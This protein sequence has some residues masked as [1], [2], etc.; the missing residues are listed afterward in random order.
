MRARRAIRVG[1]DARA[2]ASNISL[3][4]LLEL[5]GAVGAARRV[6]RAG[7]RPPGSSVEYLKYDLSD[8]ERSSPF[9]Y[10]FLYLHCI[11]R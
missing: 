9:V 2:R 3:R 6:P 10:I 11:T 8:G 7:P 4:R 1:R 5:I